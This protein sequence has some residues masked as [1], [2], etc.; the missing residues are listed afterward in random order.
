M[1]RPIFPSRSAHR[2]RDPRVETDG[3]NRAV[4]D[5]AARM[6][7]LGR[8]PRGNRMASS[9]EERIA[10]LMRTMLCKKLY[11][12]LARATAGPDAIKAA[13]PA[14]LEYMIALEK[15]GAIFASGPLT[16]VGGAPAG[17]GLT[18]LRV[19]NADEARRIAEDDPFSRQ[20]LRTFELRE[21]TLMEGTLGLKINLSDQT[22]EVA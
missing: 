15:A 6:C 20:G 18:V 10:E 13:L 12:I 21:W 11:V 16:E 14:H 22:I 8:N 19:A 5:A 17:H 3:G 2:C 1:A 4:I 7:H 9:T